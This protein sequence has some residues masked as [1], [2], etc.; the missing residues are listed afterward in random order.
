MATILPV[1]D[2]VYQANAIKV[3]WNLL[4]A[5]DLDGAPLPAKWMDYVDRSIQVI[6]TYGGATVTMQGSNDD[7]T[8]YGTLNDAFG[9]ALTFATTS[10]L[11]KQVTEVIGHMRPLVSSADGTT[12]LKVIAIC[13]RPRSG[14]ER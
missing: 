6:G 4:V 12:N 11:V 2:P 8:T 7:G 9:Q 10:G 3:T 1:V 5:A 14:Q 13:R